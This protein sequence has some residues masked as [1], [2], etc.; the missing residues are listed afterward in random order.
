VHTTQLHRR[1]LGRIIAHFVERNSRVFRSQAQL[2]SV[3]NRACSTCEKSYLARSKYRT[4][5]L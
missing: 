3:A 1:H 4:I 5:Y 2:D